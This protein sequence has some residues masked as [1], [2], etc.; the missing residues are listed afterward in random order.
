[1]YS[2]SFCFLL[3]YPHPLLRLVNSFSFD[4]ILALDL[5]CTVSW[6]LPFIT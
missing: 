1:M 6:H 4:F 2:F 5:G 3:A